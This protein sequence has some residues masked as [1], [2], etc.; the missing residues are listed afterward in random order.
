MPAA[1][2]AARALSAKTCGVSRFGGS[3][4][5]SRVSAVAWASASAPA[6]AS[7]P[8]GVSARGETMKMLLSGE[9]HFEV[10]SWPGRSSFF[11]ALQE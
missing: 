5:R 9:V 1:C 7:C 10:F 2:P 8:S 4:T 3:L 6:I 11:V